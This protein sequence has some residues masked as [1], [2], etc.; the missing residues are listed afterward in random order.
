[1]YDFI[2]DSALGIEVERVDWHQM[3]L[4]NRDISGLM[5][6]YPDTEG[7]VVDYGELIAT[8]HANGVKL[9][10]ITSQAARKVTLGFVVVKGGQIDNHTHV[11]VW[12]LLTLTTLLFL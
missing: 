9:T 1:M 6:Q 12:Y 4:S 5:I 2:F 7:N 3:D 10:I 11:Y 8:A